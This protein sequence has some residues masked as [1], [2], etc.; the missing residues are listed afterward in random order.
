M[1]TNREQLKLPG[2]PKFDCRCI[3]IESLT[4]LKLSLI[5]SRDTYNDI[6]SRLIRMELHKPSLEVKNMQEQARKFDALL[7][8]LDKIPPC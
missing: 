5:T 2:E 7:H 1:P 3:D 6:V 4:D 8:E